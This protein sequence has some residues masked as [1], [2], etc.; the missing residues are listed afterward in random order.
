MGKKTGKYYGG[1]APLQGNTRKKPCSVG[2]D[3]RQRE[4]VKFV[5]KGSLSVGV[6]FLIEYW[7]KN[8]GK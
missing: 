7:E 8:S 5:G 1:G 2:L 4:V 3:D 6:Q